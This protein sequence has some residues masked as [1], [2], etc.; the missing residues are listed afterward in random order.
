MNE[1]V[2]P[3]LMGA[4]GGIATSFMVSWAK[5]KGKNLATLQDIAEIT[6]QVE[7]AKTEHGKDLEYFKGPCVFG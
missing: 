4:A 1:Y 2:I 5:Q 6:H 7:T 3:L